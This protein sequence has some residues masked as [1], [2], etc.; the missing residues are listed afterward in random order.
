MTHKFQCLYLI[1]GGRDA[2]QKSNYRH[3][4]YAKTILREFDA[5]KLTKFDPNLL[6]SVGAFE[7]ELYFIKNAPSPIDIVKPVVASI[8]KDIINNFSGIKLYRDGFKV[9]PYGEKGGPSYDWLS[10][11]LRAQR[12]PAAVSHIS[13]SWRVRLN[14]IIG[15]V[16]ITRDG[17]P[18]LMDMA[19]REGLVINS[20]YHAFVKI[21]EKII[22][23]FEADRQTVFKEFDVWT[24]DKI[25]SVSKTGDIINQAKKN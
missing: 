19:N 9:R 8:R 3:S 5:V 4:D 15:A 25:D 10:L 16:R 7:V 1:F 17:N 18:N 24:K 23:T 2:F 14:Q 21:I 20:E 6:K 11:G 22:E 13:G 12:S